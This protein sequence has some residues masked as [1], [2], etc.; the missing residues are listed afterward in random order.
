M[1]LIKLKIVPTEINLVVSPEVAANEQK[2]TKIVADRL[3]VSPEQIATLRII[4]KSIDA[5]AGRI[6]INM[7][8]LAYTDPN[9]KVEE[10]EY[11]YKNVSNAPIV[12]VVGS[13]PAGL[14]TALRLIEHGLRPIILERGK[15]VSS[16]KV[17]IANAN[18]NLPIN[19][20]SNYC[21]GEGGAG[22]Y[23]DGK[24][25]TRSKKRGNYRIALD[26]FHRHGA[27]ED[28]LYDAHPHI[29]TDLL[30]QIIKSMRNSIIEY[31][32]QVLFDH[33]VVDFI[34]ENGKAKGVICQNGDKIEG[35]VTVIATGHS[36][37]D[38]YYLLDEKGIALESKSF[39]MGV[40]VEHP[41]EMID[42]I[43]YKMQKRGDYLPP[44]TYSLVTQVGG[45][46]VYSFCM[47]PGG[48]IVPAGTGAEQSVVNGMSPMGRNSIFGNAGIVTEV[49][50]S[51]YAHLHKEY[52]V[53]AGL[54]YQQ[55]L[56]FLAYQNGGGAQKAPAQ[57]LSDFVSGKLSS[58]LPQTSY[59]PTGHSS[60]MSLWL[61]K[62]ISNALRVGFKDFGRK[63]YGFVSNEAMILG[64]ESRTS[65]PV[66]IPRDPETL[67]H[68][69]IEGLYPCGEGAGYAGGIISAA[70]DGQRVADMISKIV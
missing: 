15:D 3:R 35:V 18:K 24:L 12:V 47:C 31:G 26:M 42:E 69:Q 5:R 59:I 20:E 43:Q 67:Q 38:I 27:N 8:F 2:Y 10:L 17:D 9:E 63:M 61:P 14:F 51:D 68:V 16:R 1:K 22:T 48:F 21:F 13:G 7:S 30:P 36:A 34:I 23:S 56:E 33:K 39:A 41:Q 52:G 62:D 19:P 37:R 4:R 28:I 57:R 49:R 53:L 29:G 55:E 64:V 46:G 40:R 44:A 66:R 70:V 11:H 6:K 45:R 50:E 58:S 65:S 54:K 25:Y 60:N 32:G